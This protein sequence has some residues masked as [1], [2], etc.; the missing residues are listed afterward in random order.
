MCRKEVVCVKIVPCKSA[1]TVGE[2]GLVIPWFSNANCI[3]SHIISHTPLTL[4]YN[5]RIKQCFSMPIFKSLSSF[6]PALQGALSGA[7]NHGVGRK[8]FCGRWAHWLAHRSALHLLQVLS[9]QPWWLASQFMLDG[10]YCKKCLSNLSDKAVGMVFEIWAFDCNKYPYC[11][12][13]AYICVSFMHFV[14]F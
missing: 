9:C 2:K 14:Q 7:R 13:E 12:L 8:R 4:M 1:F 3:A 5:S 6:L 11:A 10:R